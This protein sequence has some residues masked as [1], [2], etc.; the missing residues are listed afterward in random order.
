MPINVERPGPSSPQQDVI[1]LDDTGT[2]PIVRLTGS[3]KIAAT[4]GKISEEPL[5]EPPGETF[6]TPPQQEQHFGQISFKQLF[7]PMERL[8]LDNLIESTTWEDAHNV[9]EATRWGKDDIIPTEHVVAAALRILPIVAS[10]ASGG[11]LQAVNAIGLIKARMDEF[12]NPSLIN[13]PANV[14]TT[15][16]GPSSTISTAGSTKSTTPSKNRPKKRRIR[17]RSPPPTTTPDTP[18]YHPTEGYLAYD[19]ASRY[20]N[21]INRYNPRWQQNEPPAMSRP[22]RALPRM[23][24]PTTHIGGWYQPPPVAPPYVAEHRVIPG[25]VPGM[26]RPTPPWEQAQPRA[27]GGRSRGA[28][29]R[30]MQPLPPPLM[31]ADDD[32]ER[33][34][35]GDYT[36]IRPSDTRDARVD[37]V[38]RRQA[39]QFEQME[40][41]AGNRPFRFGRRNN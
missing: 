12:L 29:Q 20:L 6:Y 4:P 7:V 15:S 10:R 11:E 17:S 27:R 13:I 30:V 32:V 40:Q 8:Y 25:W 14:P 21:T 36:S 24:G 18:S 23:S 39:G 3:P 28:I 38:A 2:I 33:R 1:I 22:A 19:R 16:Y 31:G 37:L 9:F 26:P 41:Y 5:G 34:S 35:G